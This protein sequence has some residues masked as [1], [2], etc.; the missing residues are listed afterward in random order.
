MWWT[1]DKKVPV[2]Y[3]WFNVAMPIGIEVHDYMNI[4]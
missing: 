4:K 2:Y 3:L 1:I